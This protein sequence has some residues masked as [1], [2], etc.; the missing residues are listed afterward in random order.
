MSSVSQP[1][2]FLAESRDVLKAIDGNG[3][4]RNKVRLAARQESNHL[5]NIFGRV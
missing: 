1:N 4:A 3:L 2:R 5:A